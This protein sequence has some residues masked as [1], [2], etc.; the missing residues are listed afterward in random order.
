MFVTKLILFV[1]MF[2]VPT[3][4][5]LSESPIRSRFLSTAKFLIGACSVISIWSMQLIMLFFYSMLLQE[6]LHFALQKHFSILTCL[7]SFAIAKHISS[8]LK[9]I[10]LLGWLC[11]CSG[12]FVG[13]TAVSRK[14]ILTWHRGYRDHKGGSPR[15]RLTIALRCCWPLRLSQMWI[16][17][18]HNFW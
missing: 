15:A 2:H 17:R 5:M 4:F 12:H 6:I 11:V 13:R 8:V 1:T 10:S 14:F 9:A 16:T 3:I 7:T 18:V